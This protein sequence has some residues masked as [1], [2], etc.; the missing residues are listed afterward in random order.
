MDTLKIVTPSMLFN[1]RHSYLQIFNVVLVLSLMINIM[2]LRYDKF[3]L[4]FSIYFCCSLVVLYLISPRKLVINQKEVRY[5]I[6]WREK[7]SNIED[8]S[9]GVNV[10][11]V[12]IKGGKKRTIR[13]LSKQDVE[14]IKQFLKEDDYS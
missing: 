7:R 14:I 8:I 5:H 13:G 12:C 6:L 3:F 1:N 9:I 11:T 4:I 10:L 2:W